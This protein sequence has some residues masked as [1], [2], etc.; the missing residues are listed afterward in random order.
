MDAP[1]L[2]TVGH[3]PGRALH[4]ASGGSA[5]SHSLFPAHFRPGPV[6]HPPGPEVVQ[7]AHHL[8]CGMIYIDGA[9]QYQ[10]VGLQNGFFQRL[11]L[12]V[13][14]AVGQV[15][16]EAGIAAAA[17]PVK[18]PGQKEF[19]GLAAHLPGKLSCHHAGASLMVLSVD[20][21][22]LHALQNLPL[23]LIFVFYRPPA[24]CDSHVFRQNVF[25]L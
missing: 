8:A 18:I 16:F 4:A 7:K 23:I 22:D 12:L 20:D 24:G 11:Q 14:R 5:D 10:Q 25:I 17:G 9:C 2:Q 15:R 3:I 21:D 6:D 19:P 13:V 1:H